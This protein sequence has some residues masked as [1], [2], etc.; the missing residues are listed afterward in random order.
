M[1]KSLKTRSATI[2]PSRVKFQEVF[3]TYCRFKFVH[4]MAPGGWTLGNFILFLYLFVKVAQVSDVAHGPLVSSHLAITSINFI[5]RPDP[6]DDASSVVIPVIGKNSRYVMIH[7]IT[8]YGVRNVV[9]KIH[10]L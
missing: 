9:H 2:K 8:Y 1:E 10:A 3:L 5:S 4:I 6:D 7:S